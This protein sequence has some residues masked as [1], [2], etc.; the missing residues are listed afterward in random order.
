M[1]F[2]ARSFTP[3]VTVTVS[4][5]RFGS[6]DE[7]TNSATLVVALYVTV[8][9]RICPEDVTLILNVD[10]L[11][12][13]G[14]I[15][16]LNVTVDVPARDTPVAPSIGDVELTRGGVIST[17]VTV[18]SVVSAERSETIPPLQFAATEYT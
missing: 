13:A 11:I 12:V 16:S 1:A 15:G 6:G 8:P 17:V 4:C 10:V 3:V 2:P 18:D 14:S 5:V 7:G 9:A